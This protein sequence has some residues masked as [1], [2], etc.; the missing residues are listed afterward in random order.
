MHGKNLVRKTERREDGSLQVAEVFF[1]LQGEGPHSGKTAVFV[2]LTGCN[3]RCWFC[4]TKWDDDNDKYFAP[5]LL[6]AWV[7]RLMPEYCSLVVI[8]GG[9]PMRQRLAPFLSALWAT[10][11]DVTVQIETAGTL[12]EPALEDNLSRGRPLEF[13]VSP[14]THRI[15]PHVWATARAFKYIIKYR[16][17]DSDGLPLMSTQAESPHVVP[18]A[19]PRPG[20][21]VYLSPCDEENEDRNQLNRQQVADSALRFGHR[22]GIQLHKVLQLP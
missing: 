7:A 5:E 6:T 14:K 20:A 10:H 4:D 21:E 17:V 11:P 1:T 18:L 12:W 8:T 9:E 3:L 13:V 2:R 22:A 19:K 16:Q 15:N